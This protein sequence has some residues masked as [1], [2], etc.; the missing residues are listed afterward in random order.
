MMPRRCESWGAGEST[1]WWGSS[2]PVVICQLVMGELFL[3]AHQSTEISN[4]HRRRFRGPVGRSV[5]RD[6]VGRRSDN[7]TALVE[8]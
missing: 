4:P 8:S 2:I 7:E 3:R 6:Q 5:R 1:W